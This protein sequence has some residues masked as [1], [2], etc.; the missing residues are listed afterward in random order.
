MAN[1]PHHYHKYWLVVLLTI[2]R[3]V[4]HLDSSHRCTIATQYENSILFSLLED[5]LLIQSPQL[6]YPLLSPVV[7]YA[8][9]EGE[10]NLLLQFKL[11]VLTFPFW[12]CRSSSF[13]IKSAWRKGTVEEREVSWFVILNHLEKRRHSFL[14]ERF[15]A[16]TD[17][18]YD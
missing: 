9:T 7:A 16:L 3:I 12:Y 15:H 11:I 6:S 2:I 1:T 13:H 10:S 18:S 14:F 4:R 8:S 17:W 5:M